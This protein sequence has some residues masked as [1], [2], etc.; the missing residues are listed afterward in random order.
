MFEYYSIF[1]LYIYFMQELCG[2]ENI[3]NLLIMTAKAMWEGKF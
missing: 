2:C 1:S 3:S